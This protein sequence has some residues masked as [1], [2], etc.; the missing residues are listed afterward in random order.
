MAEFYVYRALWQ[1]DRGEFREAIADCR[2]AIQ[3]DPSYSSAWNWCAFLL[4]AQ[5]KETEYHE[6]CNSLLERHHD[7][8]RVEYA[9]ATVTCCILAPN[10]VDDW[11]ALIGLAELAQQADPR[12]RMRIDNLSAVLCLAGRYDESIEIRQKVVRE[13]GGVLNAS[14]CFW[15]AQANHGLGNIEEANALFLQGIKLM[16]NEEDFRPHSIAIA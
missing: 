1:Q 3:I 14:D 8:K 2:Q 7:T 6:F 10:A 4:A 11:K 12:S 16:H 13:V 15:L 5:G 9:I